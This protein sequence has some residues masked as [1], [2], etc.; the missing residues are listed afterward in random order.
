MNPSFFMQITD[1]LCQL[2]EYLL[3]SEQIQFELKILNVQIH[4][5]DLIVIYQIQTLFLGY[6]PKT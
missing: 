5:M 1:C 6:V 4:R 3:N 2:L